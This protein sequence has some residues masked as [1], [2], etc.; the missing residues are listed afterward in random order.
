[1]VQ[2]GDPSHNPNV[3]WGAFPRDCLGIWLETY[4]SIRGKTS[5]AI[6]YNK[7]KPTFSDALAAVRRL[8]WSPTG[9]SISRLGAENQKSPLQLLRQFVE[10]L[11]HAA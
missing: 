9:F 1:M 5:L 11:Y 6:W 7:R 4:A 3:V 10:S 2:F 8:L